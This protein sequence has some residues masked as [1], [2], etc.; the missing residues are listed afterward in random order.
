MVLIGGDTVYRQAKDAGKRLGEKFS[1]VAAI[2][3][4]ISGLLCQSFR[5]SGH[6]APLHS[7]KA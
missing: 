4:T 1:V 7:I 5:P 6:A 2:K 3:P